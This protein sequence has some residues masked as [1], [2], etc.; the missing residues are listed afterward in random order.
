MFSHL[1]CLCHYKIEANLYQSPMLLYLFYVTLLDI[2]RCYKQIAIII[3]VIPTFMQVPN[4]VMLWAHENK[5]KIGLKSDKFNQ[6]YLC[7][8]FWAN[9]NFHP[10]TASISFFT[11]SFTN[12]IYSFIDAVVLIL[13]ALSCF[14]NF[15]VV[16]GS[17]IVIL[18]I[19][20]G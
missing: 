16:L 7:G 3:S 8:Y 6:L 20:L 15:I 5:C 19:C 14:Y 9:I 12:W 1:K 13:I 10:Q 11:Y 4:G 17:L 18:Y 2:I